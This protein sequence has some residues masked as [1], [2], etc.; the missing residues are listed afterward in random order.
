L[1]LVVKI[2]LLAEEDDAS[3]GDYH[4]CQL[5]PSMQQSMQLTRDRQVSDQVI[6]IRRAQPLLEVDINKLSADDGRNVK[7][8]E[9]VQGS[10][11]L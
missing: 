9:I 10:L 6:R 5:Q 1:K 2:I 8:F 7:R 11:Q 4:L 3:L